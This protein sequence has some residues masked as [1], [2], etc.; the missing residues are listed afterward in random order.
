M[1]KWK[2]LTLVFFLYCSRSASPLSRTINQP[3]SPPIEV[4]SWSI[5]LQPFHLDTIPVKVDTVRTSASLNFIASDEKIKLQRTE[6]GDRYHY[7]PI[8]SL[9]LGADLT[10]NFSI[11]KL[12]IDFFGSL[13]VITNS[14]EAR[15]NFL[16]L[17]EERQTQ[18]RR[19]MMDLPELFEEYKEQLYIKYYPYGYNEALRRGKFQWRQTE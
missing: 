9:F 1:A 8:D 5:P 3:K 17:P 19:S 11:R 4:I 18:L 14:E 10:F 2:Y 6:I 13:L 12:G 7:T 15:N 16:K